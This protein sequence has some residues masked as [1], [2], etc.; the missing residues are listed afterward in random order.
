V[1]VEPHLRRVVAVAGGQTVIDTEAALVVHR[2]GRPVS[3]AFPIAVVGE[4]PHEPVPEAPGYVH[5][6]WDAVDT[7]IEEGRHLV[8]YPPNP[9]HRVDCRPTR[10]R[11]H[12]EVAGTALVDTDDTIILFETALDPKLYVAKSDVRMELLHQTDTSTYCNYK[13]E[14][15]YWSAT[16][17]DVDVH[18]VAWSYEE[19][20]PESSLIRGWLSFNPARADV[21][22][23]LPTQD[24]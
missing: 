4:L 23:E 7:W 16:I 5:V 6:P 3:Y 14:A 17:G 8:H 9:Y 15:T 18:D 22:A 12:V 11:L 21:T 24:R 1:Y 2:P 20:Y 10:R 19:P 13:G